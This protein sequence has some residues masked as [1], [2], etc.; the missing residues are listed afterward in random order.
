MI[1][2]G[3]LV[4]GILMSIIV[5]VATDRDI[6][7]LALITVVLIIIIVVVG[8]IAAINI[9]I[10]LVELPSQIYVANA[11][12]QQLQHSNDINAIVDFNSKVLAA[13]QFHSIWWR[14]IFCSDAYYGF[15]LLP[16]P[17]G[18]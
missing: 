17:Q 18:D 13:Q 7:P 12:Y 8:A 15:E 11:T 14:H 9:G 2:I 1:L 3:L 6:M 4:V 10:N 16:L 5:V